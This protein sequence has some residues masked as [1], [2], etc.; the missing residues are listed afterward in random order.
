MLIS[1]ALTPMRSIGLFLAEPEVCLQLK[2]TI[3]LFNKNAKVFIKYSVIQAIFFRF[4]YFN[5]KLRPKLSFY[6]QICVKRVKLSI[7]RPFV[8]TFCKIL[9]LGY[10]MAT[11]FRCGMSFLIEVIYRCC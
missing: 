2:D 10:K 9:I 3:T 1:K 8:Y 5:R 4:S 7:N 6:A 11:G